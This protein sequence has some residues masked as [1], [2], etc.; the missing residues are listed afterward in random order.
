MDSVG[1]NNLSLI[2]AKSFETNSERVLMVYIVVIV[3][4]FIALVNGIILTYYISYTYCICFY[5]L[6][7]GKPLWA[8]LGMVAVSIS[9]FFG[10]IISIVTKCSQFSRH[11]IISGMLILF[12]SSGNEV[13]FLAFFCKY[14]H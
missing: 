1:I 13:F 3:I 4:I 12:L 11:R 10:L 7:L 9:L 2:V 5:S 8:K 6:F 14:W